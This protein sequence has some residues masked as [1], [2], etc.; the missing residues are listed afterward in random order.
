MRNGPRTSR[1]SGIQ[2]KS[3]AR[4]SARHPPPLSRTSGAKRN[5]DPG[6]RRKL[7]RSGSCFSTEETERLRRKLVRWVPDLKIHSASLRSSPSGKAV[8]VRP[9]PQPLPPRFPGQVERS[10]TQIRDPGEKLPRSGS[11][12]ST[13]ETERL[14]RKSSRWVPDLKIHCAALRSSASGK[15]LRVRHRARA[16]VS[17]A[18]RRS[19]RPGPAGSASR[20]RSR[21][22]RRESA[23]PT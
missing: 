17:T 6:S 12:F 4:R 22:A 14:R 19:A 23:P 5:A 1:G 8:R 2:E 9:S 20:R 18:G 15:A 11:C 21:P 13:E 16:R 7:P 10:G 3:V